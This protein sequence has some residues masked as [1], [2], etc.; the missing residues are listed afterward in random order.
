MGHRR[1]RGGAGAGSCAIGKPPLKPS[2][3]QPMQK[4]EPK[5]KETVIATKLIWFTDHIPTTHLTF[6]T[7]YR[8]RENFYRPREDIYR[9][10]KN[11]Y[12][13]LLLVTYK[14]KAAE[15]ISCMRD[16]IRTN[17]SMCLLKTTNQ[18]EWSQWRTGPMNATPSYGPDI[19][20]SYPQWN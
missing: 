6:P 9:P 19:G 1:A 17:K 4:Q 20:D 16:E 8:P 3:Y 10:R 15:A 11:F 5:K 13:Q 14:L 18:P 12:R 2:K 7:T